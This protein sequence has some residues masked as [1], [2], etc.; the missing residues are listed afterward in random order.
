MSIALEQDILEQD[1]RIL[2]S[3]GSGTYGEVKLACHLPTHTE[4]AVKVLK[5]KDKSLAHTHSEVEILQSLEHRNIVRFFHVIYTLKKTYVVMEYV[6]GKDLEIFLRDVDHLQEEEARPIFQQVASAVHYLHQRRIA[7]RDI[8]LENILI[9]NAGNIKLCDFGLAAQLAEGQMLEDVC[10][11]LLY[12]PPEVLA[13]KPYDGLAVDMWGMGILLYVLVTGCFPYEETRDDALYR[14][15][16]N[17][18]LAIPQ[19]LSKPC[20]VILAQLLC[21]PTSHRITIS[22]VREREWLRSIEEHVEPLSK[23]LLPRIMDTMNAIGYTCEEIMS[24]LT[25]GQPHNKVAA[26]FNILKHKLS[27]EDSHHGKEK[28]SLT[29]SP[30]CALP[31]LLPLKRKASEAAFLTITETGDSPVQKEGVPGKRKRC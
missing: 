28:P 10:G 27:R 26:A 5:K 20:Q 19:H 16:T 3:I 2:K 9:D 25:H 18:Q 21:V 7:H 15:I 4:V 6:A 23:G 29:S 12:L 22:E 8:K 24:S 1:F 17:T 31:P 30:V 13:G 14:L 11:T